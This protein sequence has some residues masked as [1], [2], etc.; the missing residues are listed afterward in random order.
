MLNINIPKTLDEKGFEEVLSSTLNILKQ[1]GTIKFDFSNTTFVSS[2]GMCLVVL[3]CNT[4]TNKFGRKLYFVL[5]KETRRNYLH[6]CLHVCNRLGLFDCLPK[7]IKCYPYR[8]KQPKDK[9]GSNSAILEVTMVRNI[10]EMYPV[11]EQAKTAITETTKYKEEQVLD[12]CVMISEMLQN[13]FYHSQSK[14]P[15]MICIQKYPNLKYT[16]LV[17]VDSGIGIP[18]TI[19]EADEYKNIIFTDCKAIQESLKRGVSRFGKEEHR[20]EGLT[21]CFS[22]SEKH[23]AVLFIRSNKGIVR[24]DFLKRKRRELDKNFLLGTQIFVDFPS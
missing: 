11:I 13:I 3:L 20:G 14:E 16:Q 19:K 12:I 10:D 18:E 23:N 9:V 24:Y 2:F 7:E 1:T 21:K 17:I 4:L 22:L 6:P 8:P 5:S 15:A